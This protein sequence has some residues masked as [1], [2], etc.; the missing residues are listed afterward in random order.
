MKRGGDFGEAWMRCRVLSVWA[1]ASMLLLLTLLLR[2]QAVLA[3]SA[4]DGTPTAQ[5]VS[6]TSTIPEAEDAQGGNPGSL[7]G[8]PPPTVGTP[9]TAVPTS[10]SAYP[11]WRENTLRA[12]AQT[13]GWPSTIRVELGG[14]VSVRSSLSETDWQMAGIR[15]FEFPA[16]A[17]AA[18]TAE[19]EDARLSG[20][21][22]TLEP[23][24]GLPAYM[25]VLRDAAGQP[26]ERRFRWQIQSAILGVDAHGPANV[27]ADLRALGRQLLMAALQNGLTLPNESQ[28]SPTA[29]QASGLP[30][31][32]DCAIRFDDVPSDMWAASYIRN[33]ACLGVVSGYSDG[34]FRPDNP[35]T[36]AQLVKMVVL[37]ARLPL[38]NPATP[39]FSDVPS[40][41]IF[42]KYI[43]TA[44]A[45]N[46][47]GGYA[48][49]KFRPD[50]PVSRAQV[51]KMIV[52]SQKW[53]LQ[54]PSNPVTLCDVSPSHWAYAYVEVA[55]ARGIFTGHGDD[56]FHPDADATRAQLSKVL[57]LTSR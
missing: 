37:V 3:V 16:A 26:V 4:A 1:C 6:P 22:V 42:Y 2:P 35:T 19:Q 9:E 27:T 39:S 54:V 38:V 56:C 24:Y 31:G 36:R 32:A 51:A 5:V 55:M 29:T 7:A 34:T 48:E 17:Q 10:T 8:V 53:S 47:I 20:Y 13:A 44:R 43:E 50:A 49:G 33:L 28:P 46:L 23:F 25:A 30:G 41:H 21:A 57:V 12:F 11:D 52:L 14:R 15:S 18:F 40:S 45:Q